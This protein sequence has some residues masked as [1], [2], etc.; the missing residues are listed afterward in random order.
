MCRSSKGGFKTC[1]RVSIYSIG[2]VVGRVWGGRVW[3]R[4]FAEISM[5]V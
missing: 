2:G 3:C 5:E 1:L 4:T